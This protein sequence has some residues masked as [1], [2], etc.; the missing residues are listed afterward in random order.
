MSYALVPFTQHASNVPY[1]GA[2]T[3]VYGPTALTSDFEVNTL[4]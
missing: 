4:N 1:A 2:L 3:T